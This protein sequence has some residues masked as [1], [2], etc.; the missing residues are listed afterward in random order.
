MSVLTVVI[1]IDCH[2][3]YALDYVSINYRNYRQQFI[4][5]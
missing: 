5:T 3:Y 2:Q 4:E 1:S